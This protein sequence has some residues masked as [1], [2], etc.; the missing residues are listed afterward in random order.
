MADEPPQSSDDFPTRPPEDEVFVVE[1]R[2]RRIDWSLVGDATLGAFNA[3]RGFWFTMRGFV[4]NPSKAF[5]GYLGADRL[6]YYNPLKMVIFLSALTTFLMHQVPLEMLQFSGDGG[7]LTPEAE[8]IAEFSQRNYN[9]LLL[10]SLPMMALV[11]RLFY[12]GRVYNFLEHLVLNA[13]QVSVITVAYIVMLP[14]IVL[15]PVTMLIYMVLALVY[16]SWLYRRVLGPGW[17]R[18]IT[19]TLVVTIVYTAVMKLVVFTLAPLF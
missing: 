9:L 15:W 18:A 7:E 17:F 3:E 14:S 6:R 19:A 16:Q 13:F 2:I 10:S 4:K 12:W 1:N 5:E 8:E 11:T